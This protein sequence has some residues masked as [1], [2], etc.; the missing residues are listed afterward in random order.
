[1]PEDTARPTPF[2][3]VFAPLAE[4]RFPAIREAMDAEGTDPFARDAFV[5]VRPVVELMMELRPEEGL[6]EVMPEMMALVHLG[7]L[8]WLHGSRT[9]EVTPGALADLVAGPGPPDAAGAERSAC[10]V[11]YP[12]RRIWGE[13]V[14][15]AA[16]QPLDGCFVARAG[17][18]LDVAAV[19]GLHPERDGFT[20]VD[21]G[22][23]RPERLA[24]AD[25][26]PLFA[27]VLPGGEAA[28]L[29]S[30]TGMEELLELG[31]RSDAMVRG[32]RPGGG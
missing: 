22:G 29:H 7:Y 11:Q 8:C 9:C 2:D 26:A 23:P 10:Y 4:A 12:A 20:V 17:G 18:H 13:P 15:G 19:F 31:W 14:A 6:G 5:M 25:G 24:R 30:V 27:P 32:G 3:L 28:G 21:V 1:M 16:H